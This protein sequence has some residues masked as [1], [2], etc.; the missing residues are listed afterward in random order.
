MIKDSKAYLLAEMWNRR[1]LQDCKNCLAMEQSV[2]SVE[3]KK[4][5]FKNYYIM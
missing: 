5:V 2:A 4:N 3:I 1:C